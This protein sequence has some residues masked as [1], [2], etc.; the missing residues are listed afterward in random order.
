[1]VAFSVNFV[2][3]PALVVSMSLSLLVGTVAVP[4]MVK[5]IPVTFVW[6]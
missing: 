4:T 5:V 6:S 3:A 2:F 1:M